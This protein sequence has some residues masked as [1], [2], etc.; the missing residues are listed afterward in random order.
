MIANS[1]HPMKINP[2]G[3]ALVT[4][5]LSIGSLPY[6]VAQR[7]SNNYPNIPFTSGWKANIRGVELSN[8]HPL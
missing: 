4:G 3:V 5:E 2:T 6:L 1:S 7:I 8:F